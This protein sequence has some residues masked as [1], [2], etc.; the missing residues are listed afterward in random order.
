MINFGVKS[1]R[2]RVCVWYEYSHN[3]LILDTS[4]TLKT[5]L[6]SFFL[7]TIIKCDCSVQVPTTTI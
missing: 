3:L 5:Y 1:K 2:E 4:I 6:I 7:R